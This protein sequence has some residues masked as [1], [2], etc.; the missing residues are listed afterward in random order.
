[1][2]TEAMTAQVKQKTGPKTGY[3]WAVLFVVLLAGMTAPANMAKVTTLAPV[4]MEQFGI[5]TG[6]IGWVIAMFYVL[7]FVLAFP[8]AGL[9][10]KLGIKKTVIIALVSG[11]VGSALGAV[12]TSLALFMVSRVLEGAGMGIMGVVGVAAI[13]PWF[14]PS[15]RGL[16]MGIWG[17]W[18]SIPMFVGPLI[19]APMT[20]SLGSWRPVW[21]FT[22]AFGVIALVLFV[23]FYREPSFVFDEN[24][25]AVDIGE[26]Q[27]EEIEKPSIRKALVLPVVWILAIIMVLDNAAFMAVQ[28]YFSTY[29]YD[30][31]GF[32]LTIAAGLVSASAI[33]G[34][35]FSPVSGVLSDKIKSVRV[36]LLTCYIAALVYVWF[37]FSATSLMA[38]IPIII[39]MSW[40][41]GAA[42]AMQWAACS[43]A[44]PL[45]ALSGGMAVLVFA[46]NVGM[47]FG[48]AFFGGILEAIGSWGTAMHV[49]IFPMYIVVLIVLLIG[50]KKL[51]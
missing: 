39:L 13:T 46:Q 7:G 10:N 42:G 20:E 11:I 28:G 43:K 16:P 32:S 23:I 36:V 48:A 40:A 38:Y 26:K 25:N 30:Q 41:S 22:V 37:V 17:M 31:L 51:P 1:M 49:A 9:A 35:V 19:Y 14:A 50:W 45:D 33:L 3:G 44:V 24:E 29:V 47:F 27:I 6:A 8:A 2:A 18:V 12:S 4:I 21:W 15:K 5:G 34:A